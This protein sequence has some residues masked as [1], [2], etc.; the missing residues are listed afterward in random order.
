MLAL[1]FCLHLTPKNTAAKT[2][3]PPIPVGDDRAAVVNGRFHF[4]LRFEIGV[5]LYAL[6]EIL[7]N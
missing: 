7:V 6:R 1:Y 3:A 4:E 2:N 5:P